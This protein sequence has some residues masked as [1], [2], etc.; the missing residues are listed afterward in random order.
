[1]DFTKGRIPV[2]HVKAAFLRVHHQADVHVFY[3]LCS[4]SDRNTMSI[5]VVLLYASCLTPSGWKEL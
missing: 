3:A 1:M 4:S 5:A 2:L